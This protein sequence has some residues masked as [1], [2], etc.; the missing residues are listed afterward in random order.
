MHQW[1]P[2][3]SLTFVVGLAIAAPPL[4]ACGT[5]PGPATPE[6]A[7][8]STPTASSTPP[9][10]P[11]S[12]SGPGAS[13]P[14]AGSPAAVLPDVTGERLS[15]GERMLRAD[16]FLSVRAVDASG[17]GRTILEKGNWV[18][19]RQDPPGGSALPPGLTVTLTVL[20]PTD[21]QAP[22]VVRDGVVPRVI[23]HDLQDA[24]D[25]LREAGF[26]VLLPRD[27]LGQE[28]VPVLDRNW[29][30]VGQSAPPGTTPE[31]LE[32]IELTVV[33]F[34]EPTGN[35]GCAS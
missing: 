5:E 29:I 3:R 7:P 8:A 24:Q 27:G 10:S 16:G 14:A 23:C 13:T 11:A 30:V 28:R 26:Y 33:K 1:P 22:I 6:T 9:D 18:V 19:V 31:S 25:A 35:S 4:T 15:D 21:Q 2:R 17:D 12:P 32:K 20:R 34:G